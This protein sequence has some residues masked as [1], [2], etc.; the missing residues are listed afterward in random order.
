MEP[1][2]SLPCSFLA[3]RLRP[4]HGLHWPE[5]DT[6]DLLSK[7]LCI[8]ML[9]LDPSA[10]KRAARDSASPRTGLRRSSNVAQASGATKSAGTSQ[11]KDSSAGKP[12]AGKSGILDQKRGSIVSKDAPIKRGTGSLQLSSKQKPEWA[13]VQPLPPAKERLDLITAPR[14]SADV[15]E[16][17]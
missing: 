12:K 17:S 9:S 6:P 13:D 3:S 4:C 2:Q 5:E 7:G 15:G 16:T 11:G 14:R 8:V 10:E 1:S